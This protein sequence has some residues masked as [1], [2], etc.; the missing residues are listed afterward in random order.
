MAIDGLVNVKDISQVF[1]SKL[2]S[3]LNR[4]CQCAFDPSKLCLTVE[5][6]ADMH[7]HPKLVFLDFGHLKSGK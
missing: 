6:L 5:S 2:S 3:T 7:I 4:H 1:T